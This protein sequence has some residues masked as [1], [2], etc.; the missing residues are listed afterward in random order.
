MRLRAFL[1]VISVLAACAARAAPLDAAQPPTDGGLGMM[2]AGVPAT[3]P[4]VAESLERQREDRLMRARAFE[5]RAQLERDL[6]AKEKKSDIKQQ[7]LQAASRLA[8]QAAEERRLAA[9]SQ[10]PGE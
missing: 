9:E 1:M 10:A 8:S 2:D 6:A 7:L 5:A 4:S 3:D